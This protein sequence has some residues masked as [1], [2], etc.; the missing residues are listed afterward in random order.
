[1]P[2]FLK[3]T[4]PFKDADEVI[5]HLIASVSREAERDGQPLTEPE[6][7]LLSKVGPLPDGARQGLR[8]IIGL[9]LIKEPEDEFESDP[10]S[11]GNSL[12][13]A[14]RM[15]HR[16]MWPNILVVAHEIEY[17]RVHRHPERHGWKKLGDQVLLWLCG[18]LVVLT[19]FVIVATVGFIFHW[20]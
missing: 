11:F 8:M 2:L 5:S 3:V 7:V 6:K 17:E 14:K 1:M 4:N 19:M 10:R 18:L 13:W 15:T 12:G 20:K 16:S 9:L